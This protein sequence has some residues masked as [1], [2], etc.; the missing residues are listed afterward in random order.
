MAWSQQLSV[1]HA[2][3]LVMHCCWKQAHDAEPESNVATFGVPVGIVPQSISVLPLDEPEVVPLVEPLVLPLVDPLVD[4][5]VEPLDDP[6]VDPEP[7]S[8]AGGVELS[9]PLHPMTTIPAAAATAD[10]PTSN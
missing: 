4:P 1:P 8:V 7:P 9:S 6:L 5:L 3:A 10:S 2:V